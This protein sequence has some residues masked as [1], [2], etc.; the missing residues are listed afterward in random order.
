M[1]SRTQDEDPTRRR[2]SGIADVLAA[3]QL[4]LAEIG[5]IDE[6]AAKITLGAVGRVCGESPA[7]S[8]TILAEVSAFDERC[9]AVSPP[10]AGGVARLGRGVLDVAA[11]VAR[12]LLRDDLLAF[13]ERSAAVRAVLLRSAGANVVTIMSAVVDGVAAQPTTYGH[14]LGGAIA[15]LGRSQRALETAWTAVDESPLGAGSLASTGLEND[16]GR[17][18]A[19]LGFDRAM[20]NTF[21][22]VSAV[23]HVQ[24]CATACRSAVQPIR[25]FLEEIVTLIRTEPGAVRLSDRW[26]GGLADLPHHSAPDGIVRLIALGR[27]VEAQAVGVWSAGDAAPF[28]P[29]AAALDGMLDATLSVLAAATRFCDDARAVFDDG[30]EMNRAYLANRAGRG[31]A[32]GGDLADFLMLEEQLDP[33]SARNIAAL[34]IAR[35]RDQGLDASAIT[36]AAIDTAALMTF[37]RE[38]KVEVEAISRYLAPRRFVERRTAAGAPSPSSTRLYLETEQRALDAD[39]RWREDRSAR[40]RQAREH[41]RGA[42]AGSD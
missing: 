33:E 17:T 28:G 34:T 4:M 38:L 1:Q 32:T 30:C 31:L 6:P 3:H 16:R 36:V 26:I 18:A 24:A 22:A 2:W 10:E 9:D 42:M 37:G 21:D 12:M 27:S 11:T 25:R 40:L 39:V 41:L 23:D 15:P 29:V 14:L 19:L 8:A 35:A 20:G 13:A 7:G 5:T